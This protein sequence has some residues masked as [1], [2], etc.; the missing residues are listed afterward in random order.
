MDAF[1]VKNAPAPEARGAMG[2]PESKV[3]WVN[4]RFIADQ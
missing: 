3:G 1:G 2:L 4:D